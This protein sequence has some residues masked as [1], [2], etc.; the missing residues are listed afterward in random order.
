VPQIVNLLEETQ[1]LQMM[2]RVVVIYQRDHQ[3]RWVWLNR[4]RVL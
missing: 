1:F 2:D 4:N 3:A